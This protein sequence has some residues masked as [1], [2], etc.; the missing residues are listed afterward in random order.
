MVPSR[1][2]EECRLVSTVDDI[3]FKRSVVLNWGVH[4]EYNELEDRRS[5]DKWLDLESA[6]AQGRPF[7]ALDLRYKK[8]DI[9]F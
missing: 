1:R 8:P 4:R 7:S 6:V 3:R 5:D 9:R 2:H